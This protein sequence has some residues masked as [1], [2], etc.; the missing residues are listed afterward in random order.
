MTKIVDFNEAEVAQPADF[1]AIGTY[2][3]AADQAIIG[4]AIAY[5][6]HHGRFTITQDSG[7]QLTVN[8]GLFFKDDKV[9]A[10][11]DPIIVN[12]QQYLPVVT[13]DQK[14]IALL[15]RGETEVATASRLVETDVDTEE[16]VL[17]SVPKTDR[18]YVTITVQNAISAPPPIDYPQIAADQ[19]CLAFVRLTT[20][21]IAEIQP[22]ETWRLKTLYEVEGRVT[23]LEGNMTDIRQRTAQL[24]TDVAFITGQLRTIPRQE[25][26][27]QMKRNLAQLNRKVDVP[28]EARAYW[29]DP[30]LVMDKWD[31][32]HADWLCRVREGVRFQYA[33]IVDSQMS[34]LNPGDASL[35]ITNNLCL[36]AWTEV[37]RLAVEGNDGYKDIS[38]QTHTVTDAIQNTIS[39]VS[40][41][42]GPTI[43]VCE[44]RD[45]WSNVGKVH[46][47]ETFNVNGTQ[48]VSDGL[49]KD[50]NIADGYLDSPATWNADPQSEGHKAYAVKQVITET[51]SQTYWT[52]ITKTIGVNGSIYGQSFLNAQ[53]MIMTSIDLRF[54]RVG[55]DGDVHLFVC[56][57][58]DN[59]TPQ[60]KDVVAATTLTRDQLLVGWVKFPFT[61]TLL[62]AGKRYAWYT[63]TVGNHAV[64]TVKDNKYAQ[65][66]LFWSTDGA[67]SQGDPLYD[68][69]FRIN[70]A[71]FATTRTVVE[72]NPLTC[73]SGMT[74]IQLLY[75]GWAPPGTSLT[76]EIKPTGLDDWQLLQP[77]PDVDDNP[78]T[79]LPPLAQLRVTF[80][81][82]TDLM[83]AILLDT[84]ARSAAMRMRSDAKFVSK[85]IDF[86]L[87]STS[88]TVQTIVDAFDPTH[89]V[90]TNKIMVGST[91]YVPDATTI[92]VDD[93][94]PSRRAIRSTFT[95]PSTSSIRYHSEGSTD[96]V[97][98][99]YFIQ[100]AAVYAL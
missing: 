7:A 5:P 85:V 48:Y 90:F 21:G 32:G 47:G 66:S 81:G 93:F 51:W 22:G 27:E 98:K 80:I 33:Q 88:I 43:T 50:T 49:S 82:T 68:F 19:C 42:Y 28:D 79:G 63:V 83:P 39:G 35:K 86:G 84:T 65:G 64:A 94:K 4:G 17:Q 100:N 58:S 46:P 15:V 31:A 76:W 62:D 1:T 91:V 73:P 12:I 67:W 44:N 61:P 13:N 71:R 41:S 99:Q 57:L 78:L 56:E 16:T 92:V 97:V 89:H 20:A 3:R 38:Q 74:E 18:L 77:T 70:A 26:I 53:Q 11:D 2:A 8:P 14:W 23:L 75:N 96:N 69:A 87:S 36:P 34:L 54:T 55:T 29:Y 45:E 30:G 9:Y 72:L 6:H 40:T 59:G 10:A 24:E 25:I 95:V 37:V 60:F 52:Y